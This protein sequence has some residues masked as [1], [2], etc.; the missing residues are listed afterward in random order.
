MKIFVLTSGNE[1]YFV[2][3]EAIRLPIP[4]AFFSST[5]QRAKSKILLLLLLQKKRKKKKKKTFYVFKQTQI[6]ASAQINAYF[7]LSLSLPLSL[8]FCLARRRER[9][10]RT[11][12]Q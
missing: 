2:A 6:F 4:S 1:V 9:V 3:N 10:M 11:F 7:S 5:Q 8:S 12:R